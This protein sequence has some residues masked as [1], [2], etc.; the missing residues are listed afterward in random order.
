[1]KASL[2]AYDFRELHK[3]SELKIVKS[4]IYRRVFL[5]C[6]CVNVCGWSSTPILPGSVSRLTVAVPLRSAC[7][8]GDLGKSLR[9]PISDMHCVPVKSQPEQTLPRSFQSRITLQRVLDSLPIQI[10]TRLAVLWARPRILL[11]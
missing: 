1:M 5:N 10:L 2:G 3:K 6:L 11:T 4:I 9:P 8:Y 7:G